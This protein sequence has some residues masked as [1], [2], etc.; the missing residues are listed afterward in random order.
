MARPLR[1]VYPGA[2]Y[3][4]TARGNERKAIVRDDVD[5]RR[6]VATFRQHKC[7][8]KRLGPR[9]VLLYANCHRWKR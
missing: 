2:V 9:C 5:R 1:V 3:H 7:N 4:V 6:W 8:P